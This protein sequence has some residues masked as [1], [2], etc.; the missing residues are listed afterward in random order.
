MPNSDFS[1]EV[2]D[3][4]AVNG[5]IGDPDGELAYCYLR[6]STVQQAE[7]GRSGLPRQLQHCHEA[8]LKHHLKIIWPMVFADDGFTGFEFEQR[9]AMSLLRAEIKEKPRSRYVVIEHLDRLSR[10]ARWHQGYLLEEFAN[11]QITP[12][13]WKAFSSEIERAVM[14][15]IAEEGMRA[16]ILRMNEGLRMKAR[17]GRVT[18]KRARFGYRF[19]D[20]EGKVSDKVRTDTHYGLHPEQSKIVRLIYDLVLNERKTMFR[21]CGEMN[22][23][24]IPTIYKEAVWS[25]ATLCRLVSDPIFKGEFYA[26]RWYREETGELNSQGRPKGVMRQRPR[27][28]WIKVSVPPIVTPQEWQEAQ[29]ILASN[30]KR[31]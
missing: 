21:L 17:S 16:E 30:R 20:S 4:I 25:V 3:Q 15:T 19:V 22:Q 18:A 28:E 23:A 9:P 29:N 12:I 26:H 5:Y 2:F 7:E 11:Y 14:G 24:R 10:N 27:E 6:V 1:Q 8:A 13:F 31:A